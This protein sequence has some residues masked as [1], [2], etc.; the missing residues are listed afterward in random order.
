MSNAPAFNLANGDLSV[1]AMALG[2]IQTRD[3]GPIIADRIRREVEDYEN[4]GRDREPSVAVRHRFQ[5]RLSFNG[6]TYDVERWDHENLCR[7]TTVWEQ[8]DYAREARA[9]FRRLVRESA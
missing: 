8:Y 6:C 3:I 4:R 9:A 5:V 7:E 2:Y 1:Y